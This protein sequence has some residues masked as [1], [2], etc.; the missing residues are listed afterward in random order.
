M[1]E[2]LF[3]KTSKRSTSGVFNQDPSDLLALG[4]HSLRPSQCQSSL[5]WL[6]QAHHYAL[7]PTRG[8]YRNGEV[9]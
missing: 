7:H 6:L 1:D 3:H 5:H 4:P 9:V 8:T 2:S